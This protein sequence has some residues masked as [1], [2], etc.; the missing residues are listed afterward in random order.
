M[1]IFHQR[2]FIDFNWQV[3]K[4]AV[5]K[6]VKIDLFTFK[7]MFFD[8]FLYAFLF[9][10]VRYWLRVAQCSLKNKIT[11]PTVYISFFSNAYLILLRNLCAH[12]HFV[13]LYRRI[14]IRS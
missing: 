8:V 2:L 7:K 9:L 12:N 6:H 14:S 10:F 1:N 5:E 3:F 13:P 11:V 4:Y